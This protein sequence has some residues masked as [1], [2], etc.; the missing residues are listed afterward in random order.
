MYYGSAGIHPRFTRR[1]RDMP[2]K[3]S[4]YD[5]A[6]A[7]ARFHSESLDPL[8]IT[9]ALRLP[10]DESHRVGEPHLIRT[11]KGIVKAYSVFK[12]GMW[13]MR[14]ERWVKSKRLAV[15]LTWLLDQLEP[16]RKTIRGLIKSGTKVDF[17][18]YSYGAARVPPSIPRMIQDRAKALGIEIV[19]DHYA[20]RPARGTPTP[21]A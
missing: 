3:R 18:C 13:I 9:L 16:K 14:T 5:C 21:A 15:H 20:D 17:F 11:R 2:K 7:S 12:S 6:Y 1:D 19:I 10:A 4:P 8:A